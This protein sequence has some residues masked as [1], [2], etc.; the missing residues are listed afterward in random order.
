MCTVTYIPTDTGFCLTSSRD[1]SVS[2]PTKAPGK[3]LLNGQ[4][5]FYPKDVIAGGSWIS[6]SNTGRAAC[7]L[8]G[9][10]EKHEK[11][12]RYTKSR[13]LVLIESF[14]YS[15]VSEFADKFDF[16]NVE[17]FTLLL[18]D[19]A[20]NAPRYFYEL[21]W[22]GE[23]TYLKAMDISEPKIWSSPTLYSKE[24][25]EKRTSIFSQWLN[26][27]KDA[28]D[29]SI[30]NFHNQKH[31]LETKDAIL[32]NRNNQLKT[33]SISQIEMDNGEIHFHYHDTTINKSTT[34]KIINTWK[35]YA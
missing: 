32:M 8:N 6:I 5:L 35:K 29:K 11:A 16:F 4:V 12:D 30:F 17:P 1:E 10:F 27:F 14:N 20:E 33:L 26:D 28:K 25:R 34:E 31:D 2:R 21:K 18:L 23:S 9:A 3:Y 19:F 24:V 13:G 22:D 15:N 7:L